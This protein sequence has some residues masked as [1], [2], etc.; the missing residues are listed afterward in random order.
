L[1][2]LKA[3]ESD[4]SSLVLSALTS[5]LFSAALLGFAARRM[6]KVDY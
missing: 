2:E 3:L 6:A 5:L 1:P 4:R